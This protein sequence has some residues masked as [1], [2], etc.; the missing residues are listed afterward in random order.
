MANSRIKQQKHQQEHA[1]WHIGS[2]RRSKAESKM[3]RCLQMW[4]WVQGELQGVVLRCQHWLA[5]WGTAPLSSVP[6]LIIDSLFAHLL[7]LVLDP[8]WQAIFP[9]F[10]NCCLSWPLAILSSLPGVQRFDLLCSELSYSCYFLFD[11]GPCFQLNCRVQL[12]WN[13]RDSK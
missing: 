13:H 3:R 5:S 4:P 9:Q 6:M 10:K 1:T 8:C 7:A 11:K 2:R 12:S